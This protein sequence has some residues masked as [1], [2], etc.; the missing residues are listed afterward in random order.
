MRGVRFW[1]IRVRLCRRRTRTMATTSK[2][3]AIQPK[4]GGCLQRR[5]CAMTLIGTQTWATP[6]ESAE[7]THARTHACAHRLL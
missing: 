6:I 4:P 5:W 3:M 7:R 2:A 1:L